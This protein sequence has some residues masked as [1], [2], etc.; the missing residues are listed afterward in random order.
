MAVDLV[1]ADLLVDAP[2]VVLAVLRRALR[3]HPLEHD[4]LEVRCQLLRG[5]GLE[6]NL[7]VTA[8]AASAG[9]RTDR[10]VTVRNAGGRAREAD[11]RVVAGASGT[12]DAEL[13]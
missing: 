3:R 5:H 13:A 10:A 2:R 9:A 12:E 7:L 1:R 4:D 8:A 11:A 6:A